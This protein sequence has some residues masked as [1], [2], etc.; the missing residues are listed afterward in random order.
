[1]TFDVL[2]KSNLLTNQIDPNGLTDSSI[3]MEIYIFLSDTP[4][5]EILI[6][7]KRLKHC[8]TFTV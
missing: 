4:L 2:F 7:I 5:H 1:M 8:A 3:H 6:P